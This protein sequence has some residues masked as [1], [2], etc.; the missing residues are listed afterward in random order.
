M[1]EIASFDPSGSARKK[2]ALDTNVLVHLS[3]FHNGTE[4]GTIELAIGRLCSWPK[5]DSVVG[6]RP[7]M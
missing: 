1:D 3:P 7:T 2:V 4:R 5:A 6:Q